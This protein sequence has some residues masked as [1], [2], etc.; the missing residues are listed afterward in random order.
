MQEVKGP[1]LMM[2]DRKYIRRGYKVRMNREGREIYGAY[3]PREEEPYRVSITGI[4]HIPCVKVKGSNEYLPAYT[5]WWEVAS[6]I[7]LGGEK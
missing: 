3:F 1:Y 7:K 2:G 4:T 5:E 6:Q